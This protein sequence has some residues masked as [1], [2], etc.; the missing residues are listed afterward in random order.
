MLFRSC[1]ARRP[2]DSRSGCGLQGRIHQSTSA[3][4][5]NT[6][7]FHRG[8]RM[9]TELKSWERPD[10]VPDGSAPFLFYVVYGEID[11]AAPVGETYR[12]TI[13]PAGGRPA[14]IASSGAPRSCG[15]FLRGLFVEHAGRLAVLSCTQA[16]GINVLVKSEIS[17]ATAHRSTVDYGER[18]ARS[19][20]CFRLRCCRAR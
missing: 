17:Y 3:G 19:Q 1:L 16:N 10:Y 7:C 11:V 13:R 14:G 15:E 12:T 4:E 9:A 5:V 8:S 6:S 18:N 2:V 20:C